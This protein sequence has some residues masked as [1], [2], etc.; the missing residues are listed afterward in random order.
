MKRFKTEGL[1]SETVMLQFLVEGVMRTCWSG[2]V[3]K[4]CQE[5]WSGYPGLLIVT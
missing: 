3:V 5:A 4:S 1:V 2:I